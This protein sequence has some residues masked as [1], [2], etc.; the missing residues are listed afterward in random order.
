MSNT[1][2]TVPVVISIHTV[3]TILPPARWDFYPAKQY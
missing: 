1:S 2:L 3:V